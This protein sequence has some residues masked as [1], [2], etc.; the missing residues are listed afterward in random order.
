MLLDLRVEELG[1]GPAAAAAAVSPSSR[2][3]PSVLAGRLWWYPD[4]DIEFSCVGRKG[5]L[6]MAGAGVKRKRREGSSSCQEANQALPHT[7][8]ICCHGRAPHIKRGLSGSYR[9]S[10]CVLHLF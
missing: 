4:V 7:R 5:V 1:G 9:A 3:A 8:G 6:R 10:F 2:L